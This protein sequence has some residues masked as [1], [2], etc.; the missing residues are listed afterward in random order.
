MKAGVE[1]FN[2]VEQWPRQT[3]SWQRE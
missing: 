1:G 3:A 2:P